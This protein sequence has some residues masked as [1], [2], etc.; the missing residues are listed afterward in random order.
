MI[1][2][3]IRITVI[4]L[5]IIAVV[6]Y[7]VYAMTIRQEAKADAICN[8]IV[9]DIKDDTQARFIDETGLKEMID[10]AK[11]DPT[12]RKLKDVNLTLIENTIRQSQYVDSVECF[13]TSQDNVCISVIMRTPIVYVLPDSAANG[14]FVDSHGNII[15][16]TSYS[17]NIV[18]ATGDISCKYATTELMEF[19]NF[20]RRDEFWDNQIEQIH[21]TKDTEGKRVVECIPRVGDQIIYLGQITDFEQKLSRMK[22]FYQKAMHEVGWNHYSH[23]NLEFENQVI[24]TKRK[25]HHPA[26]VH[27]ENTEQ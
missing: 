19:G 8:G 22:L 20:L 10:K 14:Y 27:P 15:K 13:K 9:F 12:G 16:N 21:I 18:V 7:L 5:C 2:K 17:T 6:A 26:A 1:K 11:I 3:I 24:G 4:L 25:F 23:F